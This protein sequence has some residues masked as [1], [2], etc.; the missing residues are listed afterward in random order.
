MFCQRKG[1]KYFK[2][3]RIKQIQAQEP[4]KTNQPQKCLEE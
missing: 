4:T 1:E 2:L 3:E